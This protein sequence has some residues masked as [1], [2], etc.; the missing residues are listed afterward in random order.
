MNVLF[1]SVGR[2]VELVRAFC[3]AYADLRLP[4]RVIGVDVDPLAPAL[5]SADTSYIV[6][7]LKSPDYIPALKTI[8]ER[9]KVALV[10]PLI[11]PDIPVLACNREML[12]T[13]GA[14]VMAVSAD[15]ANMVGDKWAT[16][17]FFAGIGL[18][19][20][21]SWLPHEI[22]AGRAAYPLFIKPR[23]GS[24]SQHAYKVENEIALN[25][26]SRFVPDPIVQQYVQGDEIT[27][28]VIC[29]ACGEV[30]A[31]VSRKR[32]EVRS[33]EVSKGVTIFDAGIA[34]A[35]LLIAKKLP[36]IGPI[37]VQCIVQ[38]GVPYFTEINAR[39]GGGIPLGIA[40]GINSPRML[41]ER[42]LGMAVD[43][44]PM[45]AYKIGLHMSRF[46]D[47]FFYTGEDREQMASRRI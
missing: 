43:I 6:P 3:Q 14:Q 42:S 30:L 39:M 23:N 9:E 41:I 18:R 34:N 12:E 29:D 35:C 47:S 13:T 32:I 33:G 25:F 31:I 27:N 45:G 37:T 36:A 2:R 21:D 40:A 17:R 4:G 19:T 22:D 8:C 7:R 16:T 38:D 20:P 5:R 11:D 46:D 10:F 24:A 28:D 1:T 26:F 15:A 44:P